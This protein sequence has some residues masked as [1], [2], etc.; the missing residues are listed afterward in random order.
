MSS[1]LFFTVAVS[2]VRFLMSMV[3]DGKV[4]S[5]SSLFFDY[6]WI[7]LETADELVAITK[8][9]GPIGT[10]VLKQSSSSADRLDFLI[11]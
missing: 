10:V 4:C 6:R 9:V 11:K 8:I 2:K 3:I 5:S 1:S 7:V